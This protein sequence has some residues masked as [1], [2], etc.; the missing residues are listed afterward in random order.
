MT[1]SS[2]APQP[3]ANSAQDQKRRTLLEP[4]LLGS[5]GRWIALV[6]GL[7]VL[8]AFFFTASD[9]WII[10][11][12]YALIAALAALALNVLSGYAGQ[13]SLGIAF[14]MAIGAYTAAFLGGDP[15]SSPTAPLGL[16]LSFVIWLPAAGIVAA[17]VGALVGPTALRLKGFYLGI[18]SLAL[19]FIG[20]HLFNNVRAFTAISGG[21]KGRTFQRQPSA[22]FPLVSKTTSVF[23]FALTPHQEYFLLLVPVWRC[24]ASSSPT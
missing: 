20:L 12:N 17:L 13:I 10:V 6:V 1:S 22:I 21:A 11:V 4:R 23:G 16:G 14:F 19:V 5:P 15:P 2:V 3:A 9:R 8:L 18:V 7:I 24:A